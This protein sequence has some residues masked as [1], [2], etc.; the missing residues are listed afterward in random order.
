M[1]EIFEEPLPG[2]HD[3]HPELE[4]VLAEEMVRHADD[5]VF[6]RLPI[7]HDPREARRALPSIIERLA[8]RFSWAPA[9]RDAETARVIARLDAGTARLDEALGTE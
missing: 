5:V 2:G 7:G 8:A 3:E 6:R 9:R 4:T 1:K